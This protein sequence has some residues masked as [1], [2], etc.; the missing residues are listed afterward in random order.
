MT[1]APVITPPNRE[2]LAAD[3]PGARFDPARRRAAR[4]GIRPGALLKTIRRAGA[5][6]L[7]MAKP[8]PSIEVDFPCPSKAKPTF[9]AASPRRLSAQCPQPRPSPTSQRQR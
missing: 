5:W 4:D 6:A 7:L 1:G 8:Q 2:A 3:A 9:S